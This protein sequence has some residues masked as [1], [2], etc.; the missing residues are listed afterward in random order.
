MVNEVLTA[1][2]LVVTVKVAV[3]ALAATVTLA[4]TC[5]AAVLLLDR[6]TT[7]PPEGAGPFSVTVPVDEVEPVTAAGLTATELTTGAFTVKL[8]FW[9]VPLVAEM[10][11]EVLTAT[12][13]VV[14][15]KVAVVALAAT[16]TLAGTCAAAVL[17]LDRTT[18]APPEGAGP[19]NVTVPVDE[20]EPV[21][22]VGLTV[23]EPT[24]GAVTVKL[25]F[26]VA[27]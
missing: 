22:A 8:A 25:A 11:N 3:A 14:T 17:L 9:V 13:L 6:T 15:V 1:T 4:G 26:W 2:G 19:F 18:T 23:T 20:L 16:V 24:T 10:V 7:V 12:G 27:P 5:A 21:T